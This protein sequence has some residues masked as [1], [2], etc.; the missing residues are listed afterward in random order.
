MCLPDKFA[1]LGPYDAGPYQFVGFIRRQFR[2][3]DQ[4]NKLPD[5]IFS[6]KDQG[7]TNWSDLLNP[8][9]HVES[10]KYKLLQKL[11]IELGPNAPIK[12]LEEKAGVQLILVHQFRRDIL[13]WVKDNVEY[14]ATKFVKGVNTFPSAMVEKGYG[15]IKKGSGYRIVCDAEELHVP[16]SYEPPPPAFKQ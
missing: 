10:D 15:V 8:P 16:G 3:R 4:H 6:E 1:K 14:S 5:T 11:I 2:G 7:L 13:D 12:D 9:V